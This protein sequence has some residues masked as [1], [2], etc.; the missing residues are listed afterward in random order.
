M[1]RTLRE[2]LRTNGFTLLRQRKH[3]VWRHPNGRNFITAKTPSDRFAEN[4]VRASLKR[5]LRAN[6]C[7]GVS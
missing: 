7:G 5:F 6:G 4:N 1:S 2:L 3:L